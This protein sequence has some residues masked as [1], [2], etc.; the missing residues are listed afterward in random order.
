MPLTRDAAL[1]LWDRAAAAEIGCGIGTKDKR[2]LQNML[3]TVRQ[4]ANNPAHAN[5]VIVLPADLDEVW[6]IKRQVE[7]PSDA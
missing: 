4:E 3:W 6:I 5:L 2:S 1:A 7:M